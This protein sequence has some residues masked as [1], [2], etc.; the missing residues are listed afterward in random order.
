M[1]AIYAIYVSRGSG[2]GEMLSMYIQNYKI[3]KMST[4]QCQVTSLEMER[5]GALTA[6]HVTHITYKVLLIHCISF[7]PQH[8]D[9]I[10]LKTHLCK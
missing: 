10:F 5:I 7:W 2:S 4:L 1:P 9:L 6:L 8:R 3:E